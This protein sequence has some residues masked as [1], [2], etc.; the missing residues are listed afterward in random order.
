MK[1]SEASR[2]LTGREEPEPR[3]LVKAV[4]KNPRA[5]PARRA[6][7][8]TDRGPWREAAGASG[9]PGE[10]A[11][12][13]KPNLC[14][15]DA[16]LRRRAEARLQEWVPGP[17]QARVGADTRRLV[18]ELQI[19]QVELEMQNAALEATTGE[20]KA[21]L[22]KYTDLYDFAPVGCF[23]VDEQGLILEV[24]LTG[25]ALLGVDRSRLV[26]RRLQDFVAPGSRRAFLAFL[27][28]AVAAPAKQ[29]C[30]VCLRKRNG[31]SFWAN[32]QAASGLS[33]RPRKWCR[34]A[35]ADIT[36]SKGAEE[37]QRQVEAL[38]AANRDLN[39]E[40]SRRQEAEAAL[41]RSERHTSR[42]LTESM[43]FQAQLRELSRQVLS[44]QDEE[45]RRISRELHDVVAQTLAGI[46]VRLAALTTSGSVDAR[47]LDRNITHLQR[48]VEKSVGIVH[49]FARELRPAVLD[50]LGLIPALHSSLKS[51][52]KETGVRASLTAFARVEELDEA[53]RTVLYRVA[54]EALQN[55]ARH[56][57]ASRVEVRLR[58]LGRAVGLEIED[59][60]KS[61]D[62]AGVLRL[63]RNT[64]LGLLGM[65][66]RV[67]M[68]GGRFTVESAPG[69]G[70]IIRAQVPFGRRR[71]RSRARLA[72]GAATPSKL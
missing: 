53:R 60:G 64:R 21:A 45:R 56:A 50:D 25:A 68:V 37:G 44:A 5:R 54:Q 12:P 34:V 32:L 40:I 39:G 20:L 63:R 70:T 38:A 66:E 4:R 27:D 69:Q 6:G 10:L 31:V 46:N 22:E 26:E 41:Q 61:F 42:V 71:G 18:H 52:T 23:A 28:R 33:L 1:T 49:Q 17:G 8:S 30:E 9:T 3:S 72:A 58:E 13:R 7:P 36:A 11:R 57:H 43:R 62:L 47:T 2:S 16:E 35:V 14:G 55:V 48:L 15:E 59:D 24:N 65:R 67:E 51:F 19:H 29:V